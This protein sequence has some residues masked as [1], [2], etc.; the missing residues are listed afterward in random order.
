MTAGTPGIG[1]QTCHGKCFVGTSMSV[2]RRSTQ[3][4][5]P[6]CCCTS[7]ICHHIF[8][9]SQ[10]SSPRSFHATRI[11]FVL[12]HSLTFSCSLSKIIHST[13]P[14]MS[15]RHLSS[16][17]HRMRHRRR[18]S[19]RRCIPVL[20]SFVFSVARKLFSARSTRLFEGPKMLSDS[21]K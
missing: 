5:P 17:T 21:V 13:Y 8:K 7:W 16:A 3:R 15:G 20:S 14:L 19:V 6:L 2:L 11:N 9:I 12:R 18:N 10:G 1:L 4:R